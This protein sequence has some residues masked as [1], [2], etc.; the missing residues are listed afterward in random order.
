MNHV[1]LVDGRLARDGVGHSRAGPPRSWPCGAANRAARVAE[2]SM[3]IGD[4][5]AAHPV[6]ARGHRAEDHVGDEHWARLGPQAVAEIADVQLARATEQTVHKE[7]AFVSP[8]GSSSRFRSEGICRSRAP[9]APA[10]VWR[11]R[12]RRMADIRVP[13]TVPRC[14]RS[15]RTVVSRVFETR[16]CG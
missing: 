12:R 15:P 11:A 16:T 2:Y 1:G 6:P 7:R 4:P 10:T 9:S 8:K 5:A 3:Q 14:D 13:G